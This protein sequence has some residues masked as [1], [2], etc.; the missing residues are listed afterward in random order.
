MNILSPK[1]FSRLKSIVF[2]WDPL[3]DR[4]EESFAALRNFHKREG[5]CRVP[6]NFE[7]NGL[8]LGTWVSSLRKTRNSLSP[9]K[10]SRLNSIG[11]SWDPLADRWEES[12]VALRSFHKREGHCRVPQTFETNGL[13]LGTWVSNL[14][15]IKSRLTNEQIKRLNSL[16]FIWKA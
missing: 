8:K 3:A 4:W 9:K 1:N 16:G 7:T 13:K 14:R 2:R 6:Q 15:K 12:F 11:F 5:H 10:V